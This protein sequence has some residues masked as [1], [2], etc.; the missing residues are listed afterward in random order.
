MTR[1]DKQTLVGKIEI[2]RI[3]LKSEDMPKLDF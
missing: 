1:L 3:M 2:A